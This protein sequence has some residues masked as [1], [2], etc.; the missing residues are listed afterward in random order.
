MERERRTSGRRRYA[1]TTTAAARDYCICPV[2]DGRL[3]VETPTFEALRTLLLQ[4]RFRDVAH[5]RTAQG[6]VPYSGGGIAFP[7]M[8]LGMLGVKPLWYPRVRGTPMAEIIEQLVQDGIYADEWDAME[9]EGHQYGDE[10][11]WE[12]PRGMRFDP[13]MIEFVWLGYERKTHPIE[14]RVQSLRTILPAH[15]EVLREPPEKEYGPSPC[16]R[17]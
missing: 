17:G 4:Q 16:K 9:H 5:F 1:D 12:G 8:Y 11:E 2:V 3:Y 6:Y 10:C 7:A 13:R 14:T 15:V